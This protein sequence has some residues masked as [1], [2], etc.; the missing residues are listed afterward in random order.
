MLRTVLK[1]Y[2]AGHHALMIRRDGSIFETGKAEGIPL[3]IVENSNY[4]VEDFSLK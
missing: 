3:G 4:I 2:N 1:I